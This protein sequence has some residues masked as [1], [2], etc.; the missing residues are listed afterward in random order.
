M[1][2]GVE[3]DRYRASGPGGPF[4]AIGSLMAT[5]THGCPI[6]LSR[7]FVDELLALVADAFVVQFMAYQAN[8][9]AIG[10]DLLDPS[11]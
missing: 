9:Y 2:Q 6:P 1:R 10:G 4:T 11:R 7:R 5:D 8:G 3:R